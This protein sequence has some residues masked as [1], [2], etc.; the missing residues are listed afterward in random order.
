MNCNPLCPDHSLSA[1]KICEIQVRM[2]GRGRPFL[3]EL[4]Q[5]RKGAKEVEEALHQLKDIVNSGANGKN[6]NGAVT[7]SDFELTNK[8]DCEGFQESGQRK[9][10]SYS[11]VVYTKE[12]RSAADLRVM[13]EIGELEI[14]QQTPVRV[15][16]RRS[17]A[18][19]KKIIYSLQPCWINSHFFLLELQT[20]AGTYIKEFVHGDFGRT[21][22]NISELLRSRTDILQLD[23][24]G[25][26][27]TTID[28]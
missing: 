5:C 27:A 15:M 18:I 17:M 12:S 16:H 23:V 28:E 26:A 20:A 11:C 13:L 25:A 10:K 6:V 21:R 3:L 24:T 1:P 4:L 2:L 7:V 22:P 14:H 9:R 8:R 19:R